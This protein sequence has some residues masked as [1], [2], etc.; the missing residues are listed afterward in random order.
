MKVLRYQSATVHITTLKSSRHGVM[1]V[2]V[3]GPLLQDAFNHFRPEVL[4]ATKDAP[5]VV[6]R[7]DTALDVMIEPPQVSEQIYRLVDPPPQAVVTH[8]K[9][10]ELW[11]VHARNLAHIGISRAVFISSQLELA[12][13]WSESQAMLTL[14]RR[15]PAR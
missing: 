14:A 13:R 7:L 12:Y 15:P 11:A 6:V 9:Q 1:E 4:E 5:A 8:E 10:Y 2:S 3:W